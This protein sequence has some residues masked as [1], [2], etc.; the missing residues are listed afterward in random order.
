MI[1]PN[2][3]LHLLAS[4]VAKAHPTG[5]TIESVLHFR[6]PFAAIQSATCSCVILRHVVRLSIYIGLL[7]PWYSK[8]LSFESLL[9]T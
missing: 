9:G 1:L 4:W 7:V 2:E 6:F 5:G 3:R 8:Y